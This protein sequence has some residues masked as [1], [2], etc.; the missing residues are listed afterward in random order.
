MGEWLA[1]LIN[2]LTRSVMEVI[3]PRVDLG[4]NPSLLDNNGFVAQS[5]EHRLV[6]P[7]VAGSKPVKP[8]IYGPVVIMVA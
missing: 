8:A 2:R 3:N 7:K 1:F 5:E 6:T 4:S